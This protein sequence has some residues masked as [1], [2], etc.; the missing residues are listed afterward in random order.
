MRYEGGIGRKQEERLQH[1]LKH[2]GR[3][4]KRRALIAAKADARE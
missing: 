4:I 2:H 1:R 3:E